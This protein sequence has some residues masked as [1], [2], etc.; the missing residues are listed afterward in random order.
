MPESEVLSVPPHAIAG[1][2]YFHIAI[3]RSLFSL[4]SG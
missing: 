4:P 1:K 2:L 3:E